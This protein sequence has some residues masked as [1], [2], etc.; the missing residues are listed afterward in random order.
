MII[1]AFLL[2]IIAA[3]LLIY[4]FVVGKDIYRNH[5]QMH[6]EKGSYLFYAVSSAVIM[7]LATFGVSDT[8]LAVF[9]YK[10]SKNV[11]DKRMPGTI[12]SAALLP[13]GTMALGFL[14]AIQVDPVTLLACVISQSIGSI[15]GVKVILKLDEHMIRKVMGVAL[16]LSALLILIKLFFFGFG[17]GSKTGLDSWQFVVAVAAFFITGALNMAGMGATVPNMAVLLLLGMQSKAVFP[18]VMVGNIISCSFGGFKFVRSKE[19]TRKATLGSIFGV[20]GVLVAIHFIKNMN[21]QFLQVAM[22]GVLVYCSVS[23]IHAEYKVQKLLRDKAISKPNRRN[24]V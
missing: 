10:V 15:I 20:V 6:R 21:V 22:V 2:F 17:G 18:I 7:F 5:A 3:I 23:M 11:E 14:S 12:I 4:A 8:A 1:Q 19:Y 9:A 24:Y 16:L 13:V